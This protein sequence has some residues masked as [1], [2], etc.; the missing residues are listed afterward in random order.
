MK[1]KKSSTKDEVVTEEIMH[2]GERETVE[3]IDLV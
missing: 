3:I 2:A 1:E